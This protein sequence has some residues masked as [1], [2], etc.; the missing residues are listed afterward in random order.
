MYYDSL[1]KFMDSF[2]SEQEV[3]KNADGSFTAGEKN[4]SINYNSGVKCY[5]LYAIEG[6]NKRMLSSYLFD[7]T[8]SERDIESVAIDF[9]DTLK[10]Y[11]GVVK[12]RGAESVALPVNAG[13]ETVTLAGLTQKLLAFF[14]QH[15]DSYKEHCAEHNRFLPTNFYKE[16][17]IPSAKELL[18]SNNKKQIKKFYDAM[19]EIFVKGDPETVPFTVSVV[20]AAVYDS[21]EL[22]ADAV[23]QTKEECKVFSDNI[24]YLSEKIKKDKKFRATLVK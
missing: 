11:L 14:P 13:G 1:I 19:S 6:E 16:F 22:I 9:I 21:P 15:K 20:A 10:K 12:V 8:Q 4:F 24:C 18:G 7:D 2:F 23:A 3:T 17:I 5:E